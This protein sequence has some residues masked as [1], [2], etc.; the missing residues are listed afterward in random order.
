MRIASIMMLG[1]LAG[2]QAM[3]MQHVTPASVRA[4]SI[5]VSETLVRPG[6][7]STV[8]M[9]VTRGFDERMRTVNNLRTD[10]SVG[11]AEMIGNDTGSA[12][13]PSEGALYVVDFKSI[14]GGTQVKYF[15]RGDLRDIDGAQK[16]IRAIVG[17]CG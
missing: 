3:G 8:A 13:G 7:L 16:R 9:C 1:L 11:S 10:E 6:R 17:G 2:C 15:I 14:D 5:A 4:S 12:F